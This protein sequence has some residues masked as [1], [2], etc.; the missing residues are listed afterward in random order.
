MPKKKKKAECI[1]SEYCNSDPKFVGLD[2]S[3]NG[4]ALIILD[5]NG[6]MLEQKL[7]SSPSESDIEDRIIYIEKEIEFIPNIVDLEYVY[8]EGP[9]FSSNG[10]FM[11]QMGA[12]NF[13]IR[14][15]LRKKNIEFKII[16][17]TTLKKWVCENGRAKKELMILNVYKRWGVEFQDN[18]L[19]D[20]YG[21]ARMAMEETIND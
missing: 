18:N 3:Y 12:L 15:F 6:E 7:I 8:I 19:A 13:F 2:L 5:S 11:L 14:I 4:T 21:L 20:A 16:A 10:Q 1:I 17:P 9:S